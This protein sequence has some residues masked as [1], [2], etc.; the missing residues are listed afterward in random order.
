MNERETLAALAQA[1]REELARRRL[2]DFL[3][4]LQPGY[5]RPPHAKLICE[6]LEQLER[7]ELRRLI[8]EIPPR[9]GKTLHCSNAFPAFYLGRHPRHQVIL[10]S[11]TAELAED[12]SRAARG[13]IQDDRYPFTVRV[14]KTSSAVERWHTT[15]GGRLIA[16]GAGGALTGFGAHLLIVDDPITGPEEADSATVRDRKWAWF[17]QVAMTRL[18][19]DGVVLL[20][21]TR[22]HEDDPVGRILNSKGADD[23]TVLRLPA[24]AELD[25]PLGRPEGEAL[26]KDTFPIEGLPSVD[27]GEIDSRAFEAL[28]Q[29][30]PTPETGG[31][32]KRDWL[33]GRYTTLPQHM[34]V[35]QTVDAAFKTGVANDYSVIATWATDRRF[36]Y[37]IDIWRKRVEY[38]DLKRALHEQAAKH[39]PDAI[40]V[41]DAGPGQSLIQDLKRESRLPIIGRNPKGRSK[42]S[43]VAAISGLLE[44]GKVLLPEGASFVGPWIEEHVGFRGGARHD[45]QVDT[46]VLALEELRGDTGPRVRALIGR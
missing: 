35:I 14:S 27:K 25:D 5:E 42:E 29:Q 17:S 10:A 26:W 7:R 21:M 8:V 3:E 46:T 43:R 19:P 39:Q 24:L 30:R 9:H 22:W 12:N 36:F 41:E 37:L 20:V 44:A 13:F 40:Y 6:R 16:A 33:E 28:Y 32:I 11:H 2:G 18:M 45:D 1:A 38:P 23:W 31:L 15:A 34:R 4:L